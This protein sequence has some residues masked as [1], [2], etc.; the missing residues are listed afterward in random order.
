MSKEQEEIKKVVKKQENEKKKTVSKVNEENS[1]KT[2]EKKAPV[3]EIEEKNEKRKEA[4]EK[5]EERRAERDK[6]KKAEQAKVSK[7]AGKKTIDEKSNTEGKQEELSDKDKVNKI[8]SKAKEKGSITYGEL[9]SELEDVNPEEIDKVFDAFE[10]IGVDLLKD[11]FEDI[12][13]DIDELES[14]EEVD[15]S[16][17]AINDFDGINIDDPVRMYLREIRKNSTSY[18]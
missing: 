9:A 15:I 10:E 1:K 7:E 5:I 17:S 2:S 8:L 13:P 16:D 4:K 3:K 11:D 18:I 12:E 6:E 14:I